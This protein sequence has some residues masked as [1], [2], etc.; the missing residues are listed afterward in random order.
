MIVLYIFIFLIV[1]AMLEFIYINI[2]IGK[3]SDDVYNVPE[4][5]DIFDEKSYIDL[6][7]FE[8][9]ELDEN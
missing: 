9:E 4:E 3:D 7:N 6:V 5:Y 8:D 2:Q 1:L